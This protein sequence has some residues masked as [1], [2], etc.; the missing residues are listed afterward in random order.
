MWPPHFFKGNTMAT[1]ITFALDTTSKQ[2]LGFERG[3]QS[4]RVREIVTATGSSSSAGDDGTY[5][6][7]YAHRNCTVVSDGFFVASETATIAGAALSLQAI[8]ALGSNTV[9]LIIEGDY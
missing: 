8:G 6:P 2:D 1:N 9:R 3:A 4:G 5:T 7:A